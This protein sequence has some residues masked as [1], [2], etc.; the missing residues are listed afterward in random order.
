[1]KSLL[2][3]M[4]A[5]SGL[6]V[7]T[8]VGLLALQGRLNWSGAQGVP[9]LQSMFDVPVDDEQHTAD[10]TAG[11]PDVRGR[12]AAAPEGERPRESAE[13]PLAHA[14]GPSLEE[15]PAT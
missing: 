15:I 10:P 14:P 9:L 8:T 4:L 13:Q 6:F 2:L 12:E 11:Q 7:G 3:M 1:M 5:G